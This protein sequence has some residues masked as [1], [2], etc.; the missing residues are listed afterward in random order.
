MK[1]YKQFILGI[2]FS[3]L[4]FGCTKN[5]QPPSLDF[6]H[7]TQTPENSSAH[8]FNIPNPCQSLKFIGELS[9]E[10]F[11]KLFLCLN[12]QGGLNGLQAVVLD[13]PKNTEIFVGLYND[14][15]GNNPVFRQELLDLLET[16]IQNGNL[17]QLLEMVSTLIT[18]FIEAP[19]FHKTLKPL[20]T[21]ILNDDLKFMPLLKEMTSYPDIEGLKRIFHE[22]LLRGDFQNLLLSLHDF[23]RTEKNGLTG[24]EILVQTL[25]KLSTLPIES[26]HLVWEDL[27]A[28]NYKNFPEYLLKTLFTL[29]L[30]GKLDRLVG[31]LEDLL[32]HST[33]TYLTE[34]RMY[35]LRN[36]PQN[37]KPEQIE[38]S[39]EVLSRHPQNDLVSMVKLIST[40][41]RKFEEDETDQHRN[42]LYSA[43]E[44]L[45]GV[46]KAFDANPDLGP[47]SQASRVL[48]VYSFFTNLAYHDL[49]SPEF[50]A[51]SIE[52]K[53]KTYTSGNP[54][55]LFSEFLSDYETQHVRAFV[56]KTKQALEEERDPENPDQP[57]WNAREIRRLLRIKEKEFRDTVLPGLLEAYRTF[58]TQKVR[59]IVTRI[60][61]PLF[62]TEGAPSLY[63]FLETLKDVQSFSVLFERLLLNL[64][65][66][67]GLK[68]ANQLVQTLLKDL[69]E[70]NRPVDAFLRSLDQ[71]HSGASWLHHTVDPLIHGFGTYLPMKDQMTLIAVV[72]NMQVLERLLTQENFLETLR[73]VLVPFVKAMS[74]ENQDARVFRLIQSLHSGKFNAGASE[75]TQPI[76][77]LMPLLVHFNETGFLQ[78][79]LETFA[80]LGKTPEPIGHLLT[81]LTLS[82]PKKFL[83]EWLD[84][85]YTSQDA[86][87]LQLGLTHQV[88]I[89]SHPN[90]LPDLTAQLL[91]LSAP[92]KE[93][94]ILFTKDTLLNAPLQRPIDP[95]IQ[96]LFSLSQKHPEALT[97][98]LKTLS[99]FLNEDMISHISQ[100]ILDLNAIQSKKYAK[101]NFLTHL[102]KNGQMERIFELTQ[103]MLAH[104][105]FQTT[106]IF[107]KQLITPHHKQQSEL[108]NALILLIKLLKLSGG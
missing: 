9:I 63:T 75:S 70:F 61:T 97:Q 21:E 27:Y 68:I 18:N 24:A 5:V 23:L 92:N 71:F 100:F 65:L 102:I 54:P 69:F 35:K 64:E 6:I 47:D 41:H 84:R 59:T 98:F 50:H 76:T 104:H 55:G 72:E 66:D 93:D 38:A 43:D 95:V 10:D 51:L 40:L 86:R 3:V 8:A 45:Q 107:L 87:L 2:T 88:H 48:T 28:L 108:E 39:Q 82:E 42:F 17:R 52:E 99:D 46:K 79:T 78:K 1:I 105:Q 106:G 22:A 91:K 16:L 15:F 30:E 34:E 60:H 32:N 57:R 19:D 36:E 85:T 44:F 56:Y 80:F 33:A 7:H 53:I 20:L 31:L 29:R 62:E 77:Q 49:M 103:N 26:S 13:D 37:L 11:R 25:T 74:F 94:L 58:L 4:A 83:L 96:T 90:D 67:G 89:T 14:L 12:H 101:T 73:D 81:F